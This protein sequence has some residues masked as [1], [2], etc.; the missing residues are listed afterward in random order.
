MMRELKITY[1]GHVARLGFSRKAR[2]EELYE[3]LDLEGMKI[4][5]WILEK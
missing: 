5:T 2:I 1:G 3:D 4:L